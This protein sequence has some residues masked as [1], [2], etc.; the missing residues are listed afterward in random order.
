MHRARST[1]APAT[2]PSNR[3][4]SFKA[5][6]LARILAF[7]PGRGYFL[8]ANCFGSASPEGEEPK[9]ASSLARAVETP[10]NNPKPSVEMRHIRGDSD[11]CALLAP[12]DIAERKSGKTELTNRRVRHVTH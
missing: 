8:D 6:L 1:S 3:R 10:D 9:R 12:T 11:M 2:D 4:E 7:S 5:P